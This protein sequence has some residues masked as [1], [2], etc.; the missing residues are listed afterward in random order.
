MILSFFHHA[1]KLLG[2]HQEF[3][4]YSENFYINVVFVMVV[5]EK[6]QE[7]MTFATPLLYID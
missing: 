4:L 7:S 2:V 1:H 3:T 6:D 5:E